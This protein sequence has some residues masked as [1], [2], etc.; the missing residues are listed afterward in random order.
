MDKEFSEIMSSL[1]MAKIGDLRVQVYVDGVA[2]TDIG[3]IN[4]DQ[5]KTDKAA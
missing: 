5:Q 3:P 4:A 2:K 1:E